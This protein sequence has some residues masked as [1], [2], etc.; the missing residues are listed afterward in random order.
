MTIFNKTI[1]TEEPHAEENGF[2]GKRAFSCFSLLFQR[3]PFFS[4]FFPSR[5]K[6]DYEHQGDQMS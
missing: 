1:M 2:D 4:G 6:S 5:Q 3:Y